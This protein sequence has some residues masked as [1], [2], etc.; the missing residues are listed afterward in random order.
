MLPKFQDQIL[1]LKKMVED[2]KIDVDYFVIDGGASLA[3]YGLR[4]SSDID[5]IAKSKI[6]IL[7][8]DE[9][10]DHSDQLFW[11]DK[12]REELIFNPR[13]HY[14]FRNFKFVSLEAVKQMK[15]NRAEEKDRRDVVLIEE[16]LKLVSQKIWSLCFRD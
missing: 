14:Y 11:H 5:I 13:F 6:A 10:S 2:K 4:D 16:N 7:K 15:K 3:A 8:K 12:S 9:I 1:K